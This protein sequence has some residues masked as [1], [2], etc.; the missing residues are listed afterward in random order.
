MVGGS[1]GSGHDGSEAR[2]LQVLWYEVG[3]GANMRQK[4]GSGLHAFNPPVMYMPGLHPR[5]RGC[6]EVVLAV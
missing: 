2:T 4:S 1:I 5:G 6:K 3:Q